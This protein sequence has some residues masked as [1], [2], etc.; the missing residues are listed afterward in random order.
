MG[1]AS[2]ADSAATIDWQLRPCWRLV[3]DQGGPCRT[4]LA[5]CA[6]LFATV[7]G[8][9]VQY[10][11]VLPIGEE[12][13]GKRLRPPLLMYPV[14]LLLCYFWATINRLQNLLAP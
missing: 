2:A 10:P 8:D 9:V 1:G 3:L 5:L 12:D 7:G 13:E 11:G 6:I 4:V 14:V